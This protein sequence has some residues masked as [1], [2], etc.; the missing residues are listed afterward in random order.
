[1][2][3]TRT[4]T[5]VLLLGPAA[6]LGLLAG[7]ATPASAAVSATRV[8]AALQRVVR[9]ETAYAARHAGRGR[10][11]TARPG[12]PAAVAGTT[13]R[14]RTGQRITVT[15]RRADHRGFCAVV[16]DS[17]ALAPGHLAYYD[18]LLRRRDLSA[19]SFR[20]GGACR[21]VPVGVGGDGGLARAV[22]AYRTGHGLPAIPFTF[23][24][25][26]QQCSVQN[27]RG[28]RGHCHGGEI[29]ADSAT[30]QRGQDAAD[31][32]FAEGPAGGHYRIM[33]APDATS[34]RYGWAMDP[35]TGSYDVTVDVSY[36]GSI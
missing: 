11:L 21:P 31:A 8:S 9:A 2:T 6:L 34:A 4:R 30:G 7:N 29:W 3:R 12:H 10:A 23:S 26:S 20:R 13:I 28:F 33:M 22:N 16:R 32:W 25:A 17:R 14:A 5:T 18:S 36:A 24:P 19:T 1:M 27:A 35:L 15:V